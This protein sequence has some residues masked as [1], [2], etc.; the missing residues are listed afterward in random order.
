[1]GETYTVGVTTLIETMKLE[2]CTPNVAV[3]NINI[4]QS[5]INRPALQLTGYF[6]YFD[7]NRIQVIGQVE[8]TYMEKM[9]RNILLECWR[10][11]CNI[12]YHVLYF[13]EIYLSVMI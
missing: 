12:K 4:A 3:E 13:V 11:L 10:R 1:M 8:Y 5:D 7:N 2:N 9:G 6:D